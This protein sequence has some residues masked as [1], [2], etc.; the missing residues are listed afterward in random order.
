MVGFL[1]IQVDLSFPFQYLDN[2]DWVQYDLTTLNL[3]T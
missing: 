2:T 3:T 1:S